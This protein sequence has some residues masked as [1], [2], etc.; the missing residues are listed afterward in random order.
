MNDSCI[1]CNALFDRSAGEGDHIFAAQLSGIFVGD[2]RF[3]GLCPHCNNSIGRMEHIVIKT[4]HLGFYRFLVR[5]KLGRP[6]RTGSLIPRGVSPATQ[7][8]FTVEADGRT[9][10]LALS[11]NHPNVGVMIDQLELYD[12]DKVDHIRLFSGISIERLRSAIENSTVNDPKK[13]I[14]NASEKNYQEFMS[15]V[16][17][18]LTP[19]RMEETFIEPGIYEGHTTAEFS[20]TKDFYRVLS[21]IAFHYYLVQNGRGLKGNEAAFAPI[22]EFIIDGSGSIDHFFKTTGPQ[23][24]T[25]FYKTEL[26]IVCPTNWCHIIAAAEEKNS[27]VIFLQ[28]F[29]G[30]RSLPDPHY[31]T[32]STSE[33]LYFP[34]SR[35]F[36]HVLQIDDRETK[37]AGEMSE[38]SMTRIN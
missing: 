27:I 15:L 18:V 2:Q 37:Y 10:L 1:Y 36:G 7:P 16:S 28:L 31:I 17:Q 12:G 38:L 29:V 35:S 22:R 33:E 9:Q 23:F 5:P 4:T 8:K 32:I 30:P 13:W 19:T 26:G 11:D 14:V 3:R 24:V 21:K 20:V 6:K 25:P 34:S